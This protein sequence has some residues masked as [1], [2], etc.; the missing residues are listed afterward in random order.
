MSLIIALSA[1]VIPLFRCCYPAVI[2]LFWFASTGKKDEV[3][4]SVE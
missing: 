2:S 4:Q 3:F 1:A